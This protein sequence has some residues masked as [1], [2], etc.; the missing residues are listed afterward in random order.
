[1]DPRL[2]DLPSSH[3]S[4]MAAKGPFENLSQRGSLPPHSLS[5]HAHR[6]CL[7]LLVKPG[8]LPLRG[9]QGPVNVV[10]VTTLTSP[11]TSLTPSIKGIEAP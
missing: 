10:P 2:S 9:L 6:L 11:N 8:A 3:H 5:A 1:M 4:H 7:S